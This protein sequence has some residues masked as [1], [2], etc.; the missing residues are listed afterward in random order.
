VTDYDKLCLLFDDQ[1]IYKLKASIDLKIV[2]TYILAQQV[3]DI[4]QIYIKPN[5]AEIFADKIVREF[6]GDVKMKEVDP[7]L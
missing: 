6:M 7:P 1:N 2:E 5:F 3:K 4:Q